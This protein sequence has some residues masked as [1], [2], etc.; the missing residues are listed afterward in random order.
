MEIIFLSVVILAAVPVCSA[1]PS[2]FTIPFPRLMRDRRIV[3]CVVMTT[4]EVE[5][6]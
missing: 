1:Q 5:I 6:V 2:E 3:A 4:A